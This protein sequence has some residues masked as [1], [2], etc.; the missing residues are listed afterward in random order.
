MDFMKMRILFILVT[1]IHLVYII[2]E[3]MNSKN[4]IFRYSNK[5]IVLKTKKI[6]YELWVIVK[7]ITSIYSVSIFLI[8]GISYLVIL[9]KM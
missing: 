1:L 7:T 6:H 4:I 5:K 8:I 2:H 3:C 9:E